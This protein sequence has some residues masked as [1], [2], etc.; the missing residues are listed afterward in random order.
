MQILI[1]WRSPRVKS[2]ITLLPYLICTM[3]R[4]FFSWVVTPCGLVGKYQLIGDSMSLRNVGI[5]PQVHTALR[6]RRPTSTSSPPWEPQIVIYMF[7]WEEIMNNVTLMPLRPSP[8]NHPIRSVTKFLTSPHFHIWSILV[9]LTL[10]TDHTNYFID[11][12]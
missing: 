8:V 7:L 11:L 5:Y 2:V 6:H 4:C 3:C 10:S 1:T 12:L 9:H